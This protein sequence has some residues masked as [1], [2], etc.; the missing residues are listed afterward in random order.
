MNRNYKKGDYRNFQ[1]T[2]KGF[3]KNYWGTK[4][5]LVMQGEWYGIRFSCRLSVSDNANKY[6]NRSHYDYYQHK[7]YN[8][9]GQGRN[10]HNYSQGP[11]QGNL[12]YHYN[13]TGNNR[14]C[15]RNTNIN[16]IIQQPR[17]NVDTIERLDDHQDADDDIKKEKLEI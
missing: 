5:Q 2:W 16:Q 11:Y 15:G 13:K 17:K 12:F 6:N 9:G 14:S 3:I 8:Y 1:E 4:E 7:K 10:N